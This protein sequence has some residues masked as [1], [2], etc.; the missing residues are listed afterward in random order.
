MTGAV[1]G[2][3]GTKPRRTGEATAVATGAQ[4]SRSAHGTVA[5]AQASRSARGIA[6]GAHTSL[7]TP[8]ISTDTVYDVAVCGG[9]P[10]GMTAAWAA[11][12][13]GAR[14][15]LLER[16]NYLGGVLPQCV[17][18]G[19]GL[20][21]D[22]ESSTGPR[23]AELLHRRLEQQDVAIALNAVVMG[24]ERT[25]G[26]IGLTCVG[27]AFGGVAHVRCRAFVLASGC[28]ERSRG[29]LRIPGTRPA[30]VMT[31]G[32]AQ[33]MVNI[34][35]QK[36]GTKVVILGS[37]DIGLIM[38]RR[39]KL[40]G[41]DVRLVLGQ[42]AT[43][44]YRNHVQCISEMHIP[45]RYGW[46]VCS[47]HGNGQLKGVSIAPIDDH[48]VIDRTRHEYIRCNALLIAAGLIPE[49]DLDGLGAFALDGSDGV[50]L[51]GNV[52]HIHDLVDGAVAQGA[53]RGID[54]ARFAMAQTDATFACPD[55][56]QAVAD[57]VIPEAASAVASPTR[58]AQR[59]TVTD[60]AQ[61]G[62]LALNCTGCPAGCP[63]EVTI[64]DGAVV[65]VE[66][67][68]CDK[69]PAIVT[70]GLMHPK[71]TFT[72]TVKYDIDGVQGLLPVYTSAPVPVEQFTNIARACRRPV[73][74]QSVSL[75]QVVVRDIAHTGVD[76]LASHSVP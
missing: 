35:N 23:Y 41:A 64:R 4:A 53:Q 73:V 70:E 6:A 17:H 59:A 24:I 32:C 18:D 19:F 36:P 74:R 76:L 11:A 58:S 20:Y 28:R 75:D 49:R 50:F 62:R 71:R 5:D 56:V 26:L 72:G 7:G 63:V 15:L 12:A 30:G 21:T 33:Y 39:M 37:G 52:A 16:S 9:G 46:T 14:V 67:C 22:G 8:D 25:E 3:R 60:V 65:G 13:C 27:P 55:S 66:G 61:S 43:G 10:A 2:A 51:A 57:T 47:V 48:G 44:L 69:G 54:A 68:R 45:L 34:Q 1:A 31:A 40:E 29:Q 42:A 38:A